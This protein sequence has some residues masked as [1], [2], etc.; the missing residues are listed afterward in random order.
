[1]CSV[2]GRAE[3]PPFAGSSLVARRAG[4]VRRRR[5]G[6]G[7]LAW[8]L[9]VLGGGG[10]VPHPPWI[11]RVGVWRRW[12]LVVR[13][14]WMSRLGVGLEGPFGV[15]VVAGRIWFL[16]GGGQPLVVGGVVSRN[17]WWVVLPSHA[18]VLLRHGRL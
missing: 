16:V 3:A 11:C 9:L 4:P 13:F 6:L 12:R 10:E 15:D 2:G 18:L 14:A 17:A 1:M 5:W 8:C 7:G